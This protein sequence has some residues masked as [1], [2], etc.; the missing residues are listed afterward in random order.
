MGILNRTPATNTTIQ[1]TVAEG[2][3][4]PRGVAYL[5]PAAL[6]AL[7]CAPGDV[8]LIQGGRT[9]VAR[10]YPWPHD[11]APGQAADGFGQAGT[12]AT[13]DDRTLVDQFHIPAG[14]PVALTLESEDVIHSF[15][16]PSLRIKQDVLPGRRLDAWIDAMTPGRYELPCAYLC[17]MGHTGMA[18]WLEVHAPE[19]W[20]QWVA[21]QWP[22]A[23]R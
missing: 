4:I 10:V 9:T 16:L 8:A 12:G 22:E 1:L 5:S 11:G 19:A 6:A 3:G 17:G 14:R 21:A 18:A 13:P 23:G 7:G 20:R 2:L 15:F